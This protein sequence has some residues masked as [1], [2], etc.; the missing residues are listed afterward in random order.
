MSCRQITS[1]SCSC[2]QEKKALF[3]RACYSFTVEADNSHAGS[4][5]IRLDWHRFCPGLALSGYRVLGQNQ[6]D[7]GKKRCNIRVVNTVYDP[8]E[9]K[10]FRRKFNTHMIPM[11][12]NHGYMAGLRS[13]TGSSAA[14]CALRAMDKV[15]PGKDRLISFRAWKGR[16]SR[17]S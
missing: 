12:L 1:A 9:A 14:S 4:C 15:P 16:D 2:A 17:N 10:A 5:T 3:S 11:G 8:L 7:G 13:S 6:P